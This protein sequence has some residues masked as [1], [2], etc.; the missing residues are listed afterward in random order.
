[1]TMAVK[2]LDRHPEY[3]PDLLLWLPNIILICVGAWMLNR[4][5]RK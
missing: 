3:R 1:M 2:V 4:V 5:G